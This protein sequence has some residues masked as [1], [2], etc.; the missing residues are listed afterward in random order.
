[1]EQVVAKD[2]SSESIETIAPFLTI[3]GVD[4]TFLSTIGIKRQS[5]LFRVKILTHSQL[6]CKTS[7]L[8]SKAP[9]IVLTCWEWDS[10]R[11]YSETGK[12]IR[13]SS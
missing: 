1:M 6:E 12:K 11:D 13:G 9:M 5:A 4:T 2:A 10:N 8:L 3:T 7:L